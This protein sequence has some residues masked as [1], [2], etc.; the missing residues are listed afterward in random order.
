MLITFYEFN[1]K[2]KFRVLP[3]WF[4]CTVCSH[5]YCN[6]YRCPRAGVNI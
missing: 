4:S 2:Y 3:A 6:T 1:L 5:K